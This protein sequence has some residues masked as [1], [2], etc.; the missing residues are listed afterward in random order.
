MTILT[1]LFG[2][3]KTDLNP[4]LDRRYTMPTAAIRSVR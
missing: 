1:L 2:R 4:A 3:G